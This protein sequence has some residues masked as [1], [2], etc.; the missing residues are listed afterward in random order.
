[1]LGAFIFYA[2]T[3][4][5]IQKKNEKQL[6]H[7]NAPKWIVIKRNDICW[8]KNALML[9]K[10]EYILCE[11]M[12]KQFNRQDIPFDLWILNVLLL[13]YDNFFMLKNFYLILRLGTQCIQR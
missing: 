13:F 1:M 6:K 4:N 3:L 8:Y 2:S 7:A 9:F 11:M 5:T 12:T 10:F